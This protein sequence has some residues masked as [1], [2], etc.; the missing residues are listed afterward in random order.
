MRSSI[1]K[2]KLARNEPA[3]V[4]T[5]HFTDPSVFELASLMGFHGLWIDLEHHAHSL[6]TAMHMM[7]AA[8]VGTADIMA[9]PAKGEFMRMARLF[10]AGAQGILYPRC[11][12][13]A[14]AR[15]VVKWSKFP[16]LGRRGVDGGN[17]DMPYCSMPLDEYVREANANTFIVLQIEEESALQHA[18]E[19][20]AVEGVD[21]LFLGPGDY[22]SIGGFPGQMDHPK[23][24][25]AMERIAA[26]ARNT[27]KHWGR[28]VFS[29]PHAQTCM[30]LGARLLTHG[31]DLTLLKASLERMQQDYESAGFAFHNQ[32]APAARRTPQG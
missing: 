16:P 17:A 19:M 20:L 32:L 10:E 13:A 6:E 14:E 12:D 22:S 5:L 25:E 30:E 1:I 29:L 31:S 7:R 9:R 11:D 4:I 3:L 18:E 26:A 21:A 8:R 15:E 28:P 27:G 24:Q 23:L 2:E